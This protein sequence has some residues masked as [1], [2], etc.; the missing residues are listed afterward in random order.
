M[1]TTVDNTVLKEA[2]P[3]FL[4]GN[5]RKAVL[6]IHG[7]TGYPGE[8]YE[9][10]HEFHKEGYT[11][12]L[13]L[14]P[15]HGRNGQAFKKTNWKDWLEHVRQ[16][17]KNLIEDH[18]SVSIVGLSMGGVLTLLLAAEFEPERIALLAPAMAI[19]DPVFYFTPLLRFFVKETS[20]NW[21]AEEDA[22]EDRKTL[23]REYWSR[24]YVAQIAGLRK[25]QIK[26]AGKMKQVKSPALL[27]LSELDD[28]VPLKTGDKIAKGLKHCRIKRHTLTNSPHVI[29]AG[30]EKEF[31][32]R[33]IIQWI[34][35]GEKSE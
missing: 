30:P 35:Q 34:N 2:E 31:I 16:E 19:D 20:K 23:G 12:S 15:G 17:Y 4:K 9:L 25:L 14:L 26:A 1:S 10:S 6:I 18:D 28:T 3:L 32:N 33:E 11:V 22:S 27:M 5:K 7:F 24:N 13:P 21:I 29:V 8:F